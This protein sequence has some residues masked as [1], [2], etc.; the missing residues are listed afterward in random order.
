MSEKQ[1]RLLFILGIVMIAAYLLLSRKASGTTI[2]NQE[3]AAPISVTVPS[4]NMP[5]RN[6]I[7]IN[8]PALPS[9]TPYAY[10]AVSPCMCNGSAVS[11]PINS[12]LSLTFVTNEG[13]AGP[14]VYDYSTVNE[15]TAAPYNPFAIFGS[16][17]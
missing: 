17:G 5:P 13:S 4:F 15:T 14:N 3:G 12:G 16:P 1:K 9:A 8:I 2:V 10:N 11:G 7:A 6:P